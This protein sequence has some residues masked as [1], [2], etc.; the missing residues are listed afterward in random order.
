VANYERHAKVVLPKGEFDYFAGGANDMVTLR[1][2]RAAYRRLRLRPRVLRDVSSVDTTRT[3]LGECMAHPIG[4]SPTAEHRAAH[5]D[6]ELATARAA[7][8]TRSMMVVSSSA[9]TALEDVATAG[10]ANMR[11][12]F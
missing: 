9:T 4:I 3:V 10:G 1:E 7:A 12:W 8:G 5:D 2:N 6:G 11:R